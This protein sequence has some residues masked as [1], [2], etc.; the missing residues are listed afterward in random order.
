[1]A[2]AKWLDCHVA[3]RKTS[4]CRQG[5]FSVEVTYSLCRP[6]SPVSSQ[7]LQTCN[8]GRPGNLNDL[9][10]GMVRLV[11]SSWFPV[12][13]LETGT[14]SV[15]NWVQYTSRRDSAWHTTFEEQLRMFV[16]TG[17]LFQP[18]I[19]RQMYTLLFC[20]SILREMSRHLKSAYLKN[21]ETEQIFKTEEPDLLEE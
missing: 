5:A 11:S 9:Y 2:V 3:S 20:N 21:V 4:A 17:S 8:P 7:T 1:M 6:R 16:G 10:L 13:L 19:L 12:L 18:F 14:W 15:K